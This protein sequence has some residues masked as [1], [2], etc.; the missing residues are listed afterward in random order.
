MNT[1]INS[2]TD[3]AIGHEV[4]AAR[5]ATTDRF[6]QSLTHSLLHERQLQSDLDC[7]E[8]ISLTITSGCAMLCSNTYH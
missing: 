8:A 6:T 7:L 5:N 3:L 1:K 4:Q 2:R